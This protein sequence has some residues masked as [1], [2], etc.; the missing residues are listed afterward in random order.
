MNVGEARVCMELAGW[1]QHD[2]SGYCMWAMGHIRHVDT[3]ECQ[4]RFNC[5]KR[6]WQEGSQ[7]AG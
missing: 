5:G 4:S 7:Q 2:Y 6:P 3:K 1:Q